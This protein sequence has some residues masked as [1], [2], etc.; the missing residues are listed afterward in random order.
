ML[1]AAL[2]VACSP[3]SEA[4]VPPA[5]PKPQAILSQAQLAT[6]QQPVASDAIAR[7][8]LSAI[9]RGEAYDANAIAGHPLAMWIAMAS[10]QAQIRQVS[11]QQ[12]EG[13]LASHAQLPVAGVFRPAWLNELARREDW[14]AFRRSWSDDITAPALRCNA[15]LARLRTGAD[16][17]SWTRDALALW[18]GAGNSLPDACNPVFNALGER[19]ALTADAVWARIDAAAA[20]GQAGVVAASA[21]RLAGADAELARDYA[22]FLE[23]PHERAGSWPRTARSRLVASHGLANAARANPDAVERQLATLAETLGFNEEE[24]G[25]VLYQVALWT[26]ASLNTNASA[27]LNAVPASAYDANLHEW[28]VREALARSDWNAVR[29]AIALMPPAQRDNARWAWF[30]AR[31]HEALGDSARA[32]ALYREAAGHPEFHGFLAADKL[33]APYVLCPLQANASPA[34]QAQVAADS[35]LQRALAL[36][37]LD[38]PGWA[39]REWA[40]MSARFTPQQRH[41]A[42]ALAQAQGWF[43]RGLF[44]LVNVGGT[45]L[46]EELRLYELRFPLHHDAAIRRESA[47]NGLDPAWVAAQT[48]AE[49]MFDPNARS[50]A[51]ARGLMQILPA[52]GADVA[53]R[54]G[55]SWG[56]PNS[57]YDADTN[58]VLGTAYLGQLMDRYGRLPYQVIAAYNAGPAPVARW[59]E[60]RG[61]MDP[62]IWIETMTYRETR[63]YVARVL[64]FSTI[65]DWRLDGQARKV[66]DRVIGRVDGPRKAFVCPAGAD[67]PE[68]E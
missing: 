5:S 41:V 37:R 64:A 54:I 43:D 59:R 1:A 33:D 25:R 10:L 17:E 13:F 51:D 28:R 22:A 62:D 14:A 42:V 44:G 50:S 11:P 15:L 46:P 56:G 4:Q 8:A 45:R 47:R 7:E 2:A 16:D 24:R 9:A 53:R 20:A 19:G 12:G 68:G 40:D 63:E 65:Y 39:A 58:I 60:A 55:Q 67:A 36:Q 23:S 18:R 38:R 34:V 30:N 49:S 32:T 26:V 29:N 3:Q 35:A 66:S 57:L 6:A 21:R 31:A 27:R 52:T 61:H 48:R